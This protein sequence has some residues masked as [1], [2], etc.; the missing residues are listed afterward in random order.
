M[1]TIT[2]NEKKSSVQLLSVMSWTLSQEN[3]VNN[4]TTARDVIL[5]IF[6]GVFMNIFQKYC[7]K[8]ELSLVGGQRLSVI[9]LRALFSIARP[10]N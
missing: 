9:T 2:V 4:S 8:P 7:S 3:F 10:E 6:K 5:S 1:N